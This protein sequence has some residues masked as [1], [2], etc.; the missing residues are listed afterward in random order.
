LLQRFSATRLTRLG[1]IAGTHDFVDV[2][3]NPDAKTASDILILRPEEPLFFANAER[4]LAE[5]TSRAEV[6]PEIRTVILSLEESSDFDSTALD[7]LLECEA[8]LKRSGRSL[9]LARV[10]DGIRDV[11][12][13]AG[14][15]RLAE[16]CFWSVADAAAA[17]GRG[18]KEKLVRVGGVEPPRA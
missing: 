18:E 3:R 14:A 13:T 6:A 4:V 12:L 16:A 7:A 1:Q 17:A 15:G 11:L 9:L 2:S 10:K 5:V 8:G